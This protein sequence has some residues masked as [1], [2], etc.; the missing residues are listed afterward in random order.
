MPPNFPTH[1]PTSYSLLVT[2]NFDLQVVCTCFLSNKMPQK[3]LAAGTSPR[4]PGN[5]QRSSAITSW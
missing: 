5:L 2:E 3:L 4:T 1:N